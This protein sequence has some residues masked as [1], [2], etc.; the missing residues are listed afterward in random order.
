MYF[1]GS[2]SIF[3]LHWLIF[4]LCKF[5][6]MFF[7]KY[8]KGEFPGDEALKFCNNRTNHTTEPKIYQLNYGYKEQNVNVFSFVEDV[9]IYLFDFYIFLDKR[10]KRQI[11]IHIH[12]LTL[13]A[14]VL[15]I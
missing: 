13:N 1:I 7:Y 5:Q 9:M 15:Q 4:N 8:V 6:N 11:A 3:M 10:F 2:Y 14:P 12:D